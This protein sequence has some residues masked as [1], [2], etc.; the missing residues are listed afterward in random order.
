MGGAS[1]RAVR[2]A[3]WAT[4]RVPGR[5]CLQVRGDAVQGAL[6]ATGEQAE[7][8]FDAFFT[9]KSHGTG[10]GLSI[11]RRI[12][13]SHGGRLWASANPGRGATF[14]FTLPTDLTAAAPSMA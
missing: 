14:Q 12:I 7:R 3:P 2:L 1:S 10:M 4:V 5:R 13:E 9:T 6:D 8:L 11:S